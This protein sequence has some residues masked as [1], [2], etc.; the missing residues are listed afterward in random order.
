MWTEWLLGDDTQE[1]HSGLQ[2][3]LFYSGNNLV[4]GVGQSRFLLTLSC[5]LFRWI[6][7]LSSGVLGLSGFCVSPLSSETSQSPMPR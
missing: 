4:F 1:N 5:G 7:Q 3:G 6:A 2:I